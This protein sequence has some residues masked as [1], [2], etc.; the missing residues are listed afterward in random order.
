MRRTTRMLCLAGAGALIAASAQAA[1]PAGK[2]AAKDEKVW[3]AAEAARADQLKL[4]ETLV[5]IDSGTGDAEGGRKVAAVLIERL[6]ALGG[7]IE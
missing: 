4:L 6:K 7:A 3:A 1:T 5:N 2:A